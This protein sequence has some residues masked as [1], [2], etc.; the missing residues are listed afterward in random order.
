MF[1]YFD[2]LF[3]NL[4]QGDQPTQEAFG[5]FVHWGYWADP[6]TE[7]ITPL[8]FHEAAVVMLRQM[9]KD[10][11]PPPGSKVLD[12]GSGLGGTLKFLNENFAGCALVGV[13]IDERQ[14]EQSKKKLQ[15]ARGNTIEIVKTDACAMPFP[16][17]N[18]DLIL[19]V[20]SIFHFGSR[21]AF[22]KEARRVLK[23][24][25]RFIVSDFV[26]LHVFSSFM[27]FTQRKLDLISKAYGNVDINVSV[28]K[29]AE[30]ARSSGLVLE[31]A[32]DITANTLPTYRF[33]RNNLSMS[34][35]EQDYRRATS[36]IEW[37]SRIG[38]LRYQILSFKRAA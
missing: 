24:N 7:T 1:P 36:V 20:E 26:P 35:A 5:E 34:K 3:T 4:K 15:P 31:A 9:L 22:F 38:M 10:V 29:Y 30:L 17:E 25:G 21:A 32:E 37:V 2:A 27:D 28:P 11:S 19:C 6:K 23:P 8:E 18:F 14:I 33:L 12:A 13:N 16:E